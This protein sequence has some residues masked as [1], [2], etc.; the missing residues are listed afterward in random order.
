MEKQKTSS[1]RKAAT[2]VI[3]AVM[4]IAIMTGISFAVAN[5]VHNR[6]SVQASSVKTACPHTSLRCSRDMREVLMIGLFLSKVNRHI[7]LPSITDIRAVKRIGVKP[8]PQCR[9]RQIRY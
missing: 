6:K 9:K 8:L 4:L 1:K 7:R 3:V 2:K 5:F